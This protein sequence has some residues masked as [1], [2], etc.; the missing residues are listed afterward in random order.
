[1]GQG[2]DS[3]GKEERKSKLNEKPENWRITGDEQKR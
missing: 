2:S 3:K 1:M